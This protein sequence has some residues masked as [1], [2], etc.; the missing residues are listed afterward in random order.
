[1]LSMSDERGILWDVAVGKE[2]YGA[3][4]FLFSCADSDIVLRHAVTASSRLEA[5]QAL[6][7][8]SV[9]ELRQLLRDASPWVPAAA[10]ENDR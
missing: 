8:L 5:E 3:M 4:V 7:D 2:S 10:S 9:E 1:M 6:R